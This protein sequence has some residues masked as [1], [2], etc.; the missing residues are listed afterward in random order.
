MKITDIIK[1]IDNFFIHMEN[2]ES[3]YLTNCVNGDV[4][5]INETTKL[6]FECCDGEKTIFGIYEFLKRN[7][8]ITDFDVTEQDVLEL[9]EFFVDNQICILI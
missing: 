5:E 2:K 7:A 1:K 4:F 9:A 3:G 8:D 6:I